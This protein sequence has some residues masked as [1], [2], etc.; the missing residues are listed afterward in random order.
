MEPVVKSFSLLLIV[1]TLLSKTWGAP[2]KELLCGGKILKTHLWM[3]LSWGRGG[4]MWE[5]L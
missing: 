2:D 4:N 3:A 1:A 5:L